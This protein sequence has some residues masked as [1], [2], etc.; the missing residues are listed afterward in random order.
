MIANKVILVTFQSELPLYQ[1]TID[2]VWQLFSYYGTID[3]IVMV[4]KEKSVRYFSL[5]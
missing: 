5:I 4:N 1:L 2:I 3:K